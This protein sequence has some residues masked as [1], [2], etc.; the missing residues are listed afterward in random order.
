MKNELRL[1]ITLSLLIHLAMI[2]MIVFYGGR[3]VGGYIQPVIVYLPGAIQGSL[4]VPVEAGARAGAGEGVGIADAGLSKAAARDR[5]D[6]DTETTPAGAQPMGVEVQSPAAKVQPLV[7]K[8][9]PLSVEVPSLVAKVVPQ[10]AIEKPIEDKAAQETGEHRPEEVFTASSALSEAEAA[11]HETGDG[12]EPL[13]ASHGGAEEAGMAGAASS[14]ETASG[15]AMPAGTGQGYPGWDGGEAVPQGE[16]QGLERPEYPR[17]SRERG[18]EGRVVLVVQVFSSGVPGEIKVLNSSGHKR[19]DRAAVK[20]VKG[21][22]FNA[23]QSTSYVKI[24]F[25]FRLE[26]ER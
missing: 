24:A 12:E 26:D 22:F 5:A 14:Y 2:F 1:T 18:E 3:T 10:A 19:L 25:R 13:A 8:A 17:Y 20:A 6:E 7:A 16:M 23:A 15:K 9:L 11:R 4:G 21:S